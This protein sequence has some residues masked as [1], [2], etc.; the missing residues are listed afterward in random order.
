MQEKFLIINKDYHII[1]NKAKIS[2]MKL[3][4]N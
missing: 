4:H 3:T 2:E 1:K